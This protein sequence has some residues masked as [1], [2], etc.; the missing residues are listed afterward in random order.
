[1][2][3]LL[4]RRISIH[5]PE[6]PRHPKMHHEKK[7]VVELHEDELPAPAHSVDALPGHGVHEHLRLGEPHDR[8]EEK[9][10]TDDGAASEV[11]PQVRDNRLYLG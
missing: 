2:G 5:E 7:L 8:R 11:R 6:L 4:D 10:T 9:L 3:V 1:M